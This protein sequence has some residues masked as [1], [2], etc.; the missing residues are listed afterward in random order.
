MLAGAA[1]ASLPTTVDD[2]LS[3]PDT[4]SPVRGIKAV[5]YTNNDYKE[6]TGTALYDLDIDRR[7][8]LLRAPANA[9][10]L[11]LQGY[12]ANEEFGQIGFDIASGRS[13][14]V[15]NSNVGYASSTSGGTVQRPLRR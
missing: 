7:S 6:T 5:T 10:T 13:D 8:L 2:P 4:A 14:G 12:F 9:G 15:A 3:E 11:T 1:V